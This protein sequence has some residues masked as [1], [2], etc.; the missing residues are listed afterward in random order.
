[1]ATQTRQATGIGTND[2]WAASAGTKFSC[3]D[4][5]VGSANGDTDYITRVDAAGRQDW[6]QI[7]TAFAGS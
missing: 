5:G 7:V 3:V 2:T 6:Q 1:M 4:E